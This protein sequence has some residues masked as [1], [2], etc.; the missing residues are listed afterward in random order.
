[1]KSCF[2]HVVSIG[3]LTKA[4]LN[5]KCCAKVRIYILVIMNNLI[6]NII[7]DLVSVDRRVCPCCILPKKHNNKPLN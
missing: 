7:K 2:H 3:L 6:S 1:M 4:I 5:C